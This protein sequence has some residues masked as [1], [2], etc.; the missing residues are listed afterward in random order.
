[1]QES[2]EAARAT[3]A[4]HQEQIDEYLEATEGGRALGGRVGEE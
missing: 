1:M 3:L 4:E 2:L